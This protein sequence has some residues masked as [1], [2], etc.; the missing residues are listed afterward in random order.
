MNYTAYRHSTANA[1]S[2]IRAA[3]IPA[4]VVS[5][6]GGYYGVRLGWGDR[7]PDG[8]TAVHVIVC[9]DLDGNGEWVAWCEDSDGERFTDDAMFIGHVRPRDYAPALMTGATLTVAA[10]IIDA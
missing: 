10:Q 5:L 9:R 6:A 3:G 2:A 7:T 4:D 1:A 8:R